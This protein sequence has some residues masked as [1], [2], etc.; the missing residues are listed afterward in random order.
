MEPTSPHI[1]CLVRHDEPHWKQD[2]SKLTLTGLWVCGGAEHH[3]E[4]FCIE[5]YATSETCIEPVVGLLTEG[6]AIQALSNWIETSIGIGVAVLVAGL[7]TASTL[8][9]LQAA[10]TRAGYGSCPFMARGIDLHSLA[11]CYALHK[12]KPVPEVGLYPSDIYQILDLPPLPCEAKPI[13]AAR[14]EAAAVSFL[15]G[16]GTPIKAA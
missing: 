12:K 9:W 5:Y 15:L 7:N 13:Q 6:S 8:R 11:V 2:I 14:R 10:L 16:L 1:L 4:E 3:Q